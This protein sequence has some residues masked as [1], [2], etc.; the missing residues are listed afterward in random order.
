MSA[1]LQFS[2]PADEFLDQV[3]T[4]LIAADVDNLQQLEAQAPFVVPPRSEARF[5]RNSA[6]FAALLEMAP[7]NLRLLRRVSPDAPPETYHPHLS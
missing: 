4:A 2:I 6:I 7:R 5:A 3:F 1:A